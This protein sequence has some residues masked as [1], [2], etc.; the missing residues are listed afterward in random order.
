MASLTKPQRNALKTAILADPVLAPLASGTTTDYNALVTACN[1]KKAPAVLSWRARV[2]PVEIDAATPWANF[3]TIT[4]AAK[5][6]SYLHAFLRYQRDFAS[7]KI[8]KWLTDVWGNAT[9]GS[10]AE[11]ILLGCAVEDATWAQAAIGG[12]SES[13]NAVTALDRA[14]DGDV[15]L[16]DILKM[17]NA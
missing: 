3:D 5:R 11:T 16:D 1:A 4:V 12:S 2:D 8:R 15:T 17:F 9:V 6:D 10:N 14:F 7:A 13:V